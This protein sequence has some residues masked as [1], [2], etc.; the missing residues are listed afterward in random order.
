MKGGLKEAIIEGREMCTVGEAENSYHTGP[1]KR[2]SR[3]SAKN[4]LKRLGSCKADG[5]AKALGQSRQ[6]KA[7]T[8]VT[9]FNCLLCAT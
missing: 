9:V 2:C 4:G 7:A 5:L 8:K 3:L 1:R 6:L